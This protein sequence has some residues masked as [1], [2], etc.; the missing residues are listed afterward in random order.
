MFTSSRAGLV[1]WGVDGGE[2][3]VPPS[4]EYGSM[5]EVIVCLRPVCWNPLLPD[6]NGGRAVEAQAVGTRAAL[7]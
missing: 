7:W 2:G 1:F 3:E 4:A 5:A 6:Q